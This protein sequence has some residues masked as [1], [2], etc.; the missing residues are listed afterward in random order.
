MRLLKAT[1]D[2]YVV[3][4]DTPVS[5]T[6]PRTPM[7]T[8]GGMSFSGDVEFTLPLDRNH[9][10]LG[11]GKGTEGTQPVSESVVREIN[12]RTIKRAYKEVYASVNLPSLATAVD[13]HL[14]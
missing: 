7:F 1:G 8:E 6:D 10:L 2:G 14:R 3:T 9:V 13:K 5:L 12:R 4:S 11:S